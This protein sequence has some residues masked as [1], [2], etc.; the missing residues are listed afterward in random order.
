MQQTNVAQSRYFLKVA[1]GA[2]FYEYRPMRSRLDFGSNEPWEPATHRSH[3]PH[4]TH[5]T[6]PQRH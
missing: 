1:S 6:S 5:H 3:S 4:T 2:E